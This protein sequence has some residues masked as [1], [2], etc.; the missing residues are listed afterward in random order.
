[1]KNVYQS[2][3]MV[4]PAWT[5]LPL[6]LLGTSITVAE[7]PIERSNEESAERVCQIRSA[8]IETAS[9]R[10]DSKIVVVEKRDFCVRTEAIYN[11]CS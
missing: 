9:K 1:M 5:F 10:V 6:I 7:S 8:S 4:S 11:Q 2:E 3:Y